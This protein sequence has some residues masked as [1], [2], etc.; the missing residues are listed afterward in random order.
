MQSLYYAVH[1]SASQFLE[2]AGPSLLA[3]ERVSNI[4]LPIAMKLMEKEQHHEF[5][6]PGQFWITAWSISRSSP[7]L[8][9]VLSCTENTL[10]AYPLFL[11]CLRDVSSLSESWIEQNMLEL[12]HQIANLVDPERVFS[13]Y[14]QERLSLSLCRHWSNLTGNSIVPEPYYEAS[15][16]YCTPSTLVKSPL[17]LPRGHEMRAARNEDLQGIARLCREFA[18]DSVGLPSFRYEDIY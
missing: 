4:I 8:E 15:S 6:A 10:G 11:V 3:R 2:A 12:A 14:G 5:V 7:V 13:I 1:H 9:Y 17:S 16:S 18:D